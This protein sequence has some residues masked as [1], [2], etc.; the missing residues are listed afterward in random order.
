MLKKYLVKVPF[1]HVRVHVCSSNTFEYFAQ[2]LKCLFYLSNF[3]NKS[4]KQLSAHEK[5]LFEIC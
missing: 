4:Q 1:M 3:D 2:D 5:K